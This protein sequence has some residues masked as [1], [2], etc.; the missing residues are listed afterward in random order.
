MTESTTLKRFIFFFDSKEVRGGHQIS[1]RLFWIVAF[2]TSVT[3]ARKYRLKMIYLQIRPLT[4]PIN[5]EMC[6][7]TLSSVFD[8]NKTIDEGGSRVHVIFTTYGISVRRG[9]VWVTLTRRRLVWFLLLL[10]DHGRILQQGLFGWDVISCQQIHRKQEI[11]SVLN[12]K[13]TELILSFSFLFVKLSFDHVDLVHF[14]L[15]TFP[16][17]WR[18]TTVDRM[19]LFRNPHRS[20]NYIDTLAFFKRK[21]RFLFIWILITW[22]PAFQIDLNFVDVHIVRFQVCWLKWKLSLGHLFGFDVLRYL[23][24]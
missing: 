24:D 1:L 15:Q 16:L 13:L 4:V 6:S 20:D 7:V 8:L 9:V 22:Y 11:S 10:F 18:T 3:T 19:V 23:L 14:S 12:H 21:R 17:A 5:M 2:R